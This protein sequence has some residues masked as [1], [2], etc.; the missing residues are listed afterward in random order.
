[1]ERQTPVFIKVEEYKDVLNILDLIKNKV[2]EAKTTVHEINELKNQEDTELAIWANEIA[3]IER[4]IEFIDQTLF[5]P[6]NL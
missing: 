6:E 5:E 1:M 3:D 2:R 4:K